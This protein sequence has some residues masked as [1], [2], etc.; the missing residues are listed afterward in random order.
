MASCKRKKKNSSRQTAQM[1][2]ENMHSSNL[3]LAS[4]GNLE[5]RLGSAVAYSGLCA[6]AGYSIGYALYTCICFPLLL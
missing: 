1:L 4:M 6:R 5:A 2:L 3:V